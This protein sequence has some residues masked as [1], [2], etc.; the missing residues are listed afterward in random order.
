MNLV[1]ID[2]GSLVE[3]TSTVNSVGILYPGE[4]MDIILSGDLILSM[5]ISLDQESDRPHLHFSSVL[6]VFQTFHLPKPRSLTKPNF[7]YYFT[8]QEH[9]NSI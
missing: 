4:R 3:P 2:G 5:T 7:S 9:T 8:E 1:Q 6:T